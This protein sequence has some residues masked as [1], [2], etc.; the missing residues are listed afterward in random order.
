MSVHIGAQAGDIA[1]I[2]LLPGDPLRAKWAANTFLEDVKCYTEV[3]GMLGFTGT[4][5][6]RRV[7][8][9]GTGMGIPSHIIY[10][11]ELL[12]EYGAK[13]LVRVGSCGSLQE[14]LHLRDIVVAT[15]ASSDSNINATRF[16]GAVYC[17]SVDPGLFRRAMDVADS[18]EVPARAG[19]ILSTDVF[20][21]DDL[22]GW[23]LWSRFGVLAVE[24]ETYGLF[25][26]AALF[27]AKALS[28]LTVSDEL[29]T[30]AVLSSQQREQSF[31]TMMRL[32][33]TTVLKEER[34]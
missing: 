14:D 22:E 19:G 5:E 15:T 27:G 23:R 20:Y 30:G 2:V 1:D 8:I 12:A 17:P 25:T 33:L 7:S 13:V 21:G 24:M 29:A 26:E 9:Q 31:E 28:V 32:A 4:W 18:M 34:R 6:G 16:P 3:R 10:V 11:H